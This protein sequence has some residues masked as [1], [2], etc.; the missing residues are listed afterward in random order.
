MNLYYTDGRVAA[1]LLANAFATEAYTDAKVAD[2][3]S[4]AI[5][6]SLSGAGS[7]GSIVNVA[8]KAYYV[9]RIVVDVTSAF[10]A[11]ISITDGTNTLMGAAS[12]E[13][14]VVGAY[15]AEMDFATATAGGASIS[16][17][18]AATAGAA[19]VTVEYIQ[20]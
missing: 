4:F 6:A 12:I 16:L 18:T 7:I 17:A 8:G 15:V 9:S 20:M 19:T 11:E 3:D 5:R 10:D 13:E 1:Y 2:K 14:N